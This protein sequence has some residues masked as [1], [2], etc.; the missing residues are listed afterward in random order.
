[1]INLAIFISGRIKFYNK[2]LIPIIQHLKSQ[3]KYN[4]RIFFS[5][6]NDSV[7]EDVI[8]CFKNELGYYEFKPF[9]YEKDWVE[10][11]LKN[12]R[13]YLG[14]YNQLSCF[15]NDLNN[16]N[17]I[18]KYEKDNN[19][20]FDIICK[21]RSDIIFRNLNQVNFH[22]DDSKELILNNIN[23]WCIIRAFNL[24]PP[25]MSDAICF[26]NKNSM[27]IYCNTY[28]FI[29]N[30]DIK[31]N[32]LYNRT[33]EPYLNE[34]LYNCLFCG[35][36][37]YKNIIKTSPYTREEFIN[38]FNHKYSEEDKKFIRKDYDWK[39]SIIRQNDKINDYTPPKDVIINNEKY[40]WKSSW[41]G[42]IHHSYINETNS[43]I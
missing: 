30:M 22:K 41:T 7:I 39:Y 4:I 37:S 28:N 20:E 35:I 14:S 24:S 32:G 10:N 33:F 13:K 43:F 16:F 21:L 36:P 27:K 1:M 29:K 18:E 40:I 3:K 17:L 11:R 2:C 6:N 42:L 38:I 23:L 9:F 8:E 12:N 15:Y 26:G 25:L 31:L 34:S 19:I 5:I